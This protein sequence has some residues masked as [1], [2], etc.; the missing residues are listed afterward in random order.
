MSEAAGW[1]PHLFCRVSR[2]FA[3]SASSACAP[4]D[5]VEVLAGIAI[6][7]DGDFPRL[8]ILRLRSSAEKGLVLKTSGRRREATLRTAVKRCP[9]G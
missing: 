2:G 1:E 5:A 9:F 6:Y 3:Q 8:P 7:P 4:P